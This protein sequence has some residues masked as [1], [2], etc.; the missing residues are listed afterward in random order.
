MWV[1]SILGFSM[2]WLLD[3]YVES[4]LWW[5]SSILGFYIDRLLDY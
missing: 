3:Y 5:V 4:Y 2:D 1:S